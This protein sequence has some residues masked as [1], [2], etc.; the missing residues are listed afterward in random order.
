MW[1]KIA[2]PASHM[3][4]HKHAALRSWRRLCPRNRNTVM[5]SC[6][7]T[8]SVFVSDGHFAREVYGCAVWG[9]TILLMV[10]AHA[11]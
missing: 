11:H 4:P 6:N 9:A 7:S 1:V 3:S 5:L 8:N 10:R 2:L